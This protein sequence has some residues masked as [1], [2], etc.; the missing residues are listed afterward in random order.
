MIEKIFK[1]PLG[2]RKSPEGKFGEQKK[3]VVEGM[4]EKEKKDPFLLLFENLKEKGEKIDHSGEKI[5]SEK[6]PA[7][8]EGIFLRIDL[9]EG[10]GWAELPEETIVNYFDGSESNGLNVVVEGNVI[11]LDASRAKQ[12][13]IR[14]RGKIISLD[15]SGSR[16]VRVVVEKGGEIIELDVSEGRNIVI[17]VKEGGKIHSID[18]SGTKDIQILEKKEG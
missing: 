2:E 7:K 1:G 12:P 13:V 16:G 3:E 10:S 8:F 11:T 6:E 14:V 9:S 17:E 5:G 18:R 15:L 4:V